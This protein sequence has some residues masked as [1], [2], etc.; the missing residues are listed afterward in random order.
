MGLF[1]FFKNNESDQSATQLEAV[2]R[3]KFAHLGDEKLKNYA[4]IAGL[5]ARV[6]YSDL[7]IEKSEIENSSRVLHES[8]HLSL[9][10]AKELAILAMEHVKTFIDRDNQVYTRHLSEH[11]DQEQKYNLLV[12]LFEVCAADGNVENLE[13]EE[14][15]LISKGLLL[16]NDVF[17]AARATVLSHLGASR[18]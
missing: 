14:I 12:A 4:C 7:K 18:Q 6:A 16:D 5:L 1:S 8:Y 13:S 17:R 15:R 9:E 3:E 11:L 10:D 2:M